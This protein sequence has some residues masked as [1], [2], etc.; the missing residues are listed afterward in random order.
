MTKKQ[1][2]KLAQQIV[3]LELIHSD[4]SSSKEVKTNV[5]NR[6]IQLSGMLSCLPNGLEVM[7]EI[8]LMVQ[9]A[10]AEKENNNKNEKEN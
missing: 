5:E 1:I 9:K 3:E 7:G 4:P 2:K 8:D 10:L 6:I